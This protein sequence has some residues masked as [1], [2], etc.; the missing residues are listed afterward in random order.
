MTYY[1]VKENA[2]SINDLSL[3]IVFLLSLIRYCADENLMYLDS[4]NNLKHEK[5]TPSYNFDL[6][7]IEQLYAAGVIAI[8]TVTNLKYLSVSGDYVYFNDE[9]MC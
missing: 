7:I 2:L 9:F 6:L 4:L 3:K 8:S 1:F 5:L